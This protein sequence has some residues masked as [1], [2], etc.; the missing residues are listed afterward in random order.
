M[1]I[2]KVY[3]KPNKPQFWHLVKYRP[4][5]GLLVNYPLDV[6]YGKRTAKWVL[7]QD[8]HIDWIVEFEGEH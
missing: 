5:W 4:D 7:P 3:I 2:A 1:I 8:I 6:P